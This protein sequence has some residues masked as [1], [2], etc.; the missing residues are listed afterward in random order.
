MPI[1]DRPGPVH[2][3]GPALTTDAAKRRAASSLFPPPKA[4]AAAALACC[5]SAPSMAWAADDPWI[6]PDKALHFTA[7]FTLSAGGYGLGSLAFQGRLGRILT[8]AGVALGAGVAKE[9]YDMTGSGSPSW[10]DF[11][12]DA[13]G[14]GC[15]LLLAWTVDRLLF[16]AEP[17]LPM[18]ASLERFDS[19]AGVRLSTAVSAPVPDD[20]AVL[21][22]VPRPVFRDLGLQELLQGKLNAPLREPIRVAD[23]VLVHRLGGPPDAVHDSMERL[24]CIGECARG[25]T[26]GLLGALWLARSNVTTFADD[27]RR[28]IAVGDPPHGR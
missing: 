26:A 21:L 23:H 13:I 6:G 22:Q 12:W 17:S 28:A 4:F 18:E 20:L 25:W 2:G 10:R 16:G 8:G 15:G 11:A 24:H 5:I 3:Q 14:T 9:I 27:P 1:L 7:G 19:P